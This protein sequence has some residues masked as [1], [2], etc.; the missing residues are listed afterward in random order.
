MCVCVC[1]RVSSSRPA[2][3]L[4]CRVRGSWR[5]SPNGL[6]GRVQGFPLR[7]RGQ[8]LC[9]HLTCATFDKR[10]LSCRRIP[11]HRCSVTDGRSPADEWR[12]DPFGRFAAVDRLLAC[13]LPQRAPHLLGSGALTLDELMNMRRVAELLAPGPSLCQLAAQE[14][15]NRR[16]PLCRISFVAT[17]FTHTKLIAAIASTGHIGSG[18]CADE[19]SDLRD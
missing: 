9:R 14:V 8:S 12:H 13:A 16:F 4:T 19:S 6:S 10:L 2:P 3:C 1:E 5:A 17:T 18:Q 11:R 7:A 15:A